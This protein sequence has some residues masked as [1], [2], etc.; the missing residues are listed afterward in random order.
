MAQTPGDDVYSGRHCT[1]YIDNANAQPS[2]LDLHPSPSTSPSTPNFRAT[3]PEGL[4]DCIPPPYSALDAMDVGRDLVGAHRSYGH[5]NLLQYA[6]TPSG[7]ANEDACQERINDDVESD[8][9]AAARFPSKS[10]WRTTPFDYDALPIAHKFIPPG[11]FTKKERE[12]AL[13]SIPLELESTDLITFTFPPELHGIAW[14]IDPGKECLQRFQGV[15]HR[16]TQVILHGIRNTSFRYFFTRKRTTIGDNVYVEAIAFDALWN[17]EP[18]M[19]VSWPPIAIILPQKR[20]EI[21]DAGGE[22]WK[23]PF[24]ILGYL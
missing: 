23:R 2:T 19:S 8:I 18:E 6:A 24:S 11:V 17:W 1:F 21:P 5:T 15:V 4:N 22:G 10:F 16:G 20:V 14:A 13:T 7:T 12:R 3:S 9:A